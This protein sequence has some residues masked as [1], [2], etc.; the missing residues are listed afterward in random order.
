MERTAED[1]AL[2]YFLKFS[3]IN[4]KLLT[5][6]NND[7]MMRVR[8]EGISMKTKYPSAK[9]TLWA[10]RLIGL[11]L[12]VLLFALP[13]LLDWYAKIRSL[14]AL[15]RTAILAAFY[16]CAVIIAAAL[17]QMEC[18]LRN[19]LKEQVFL[20]ENVRHI[21]TV[22]WCC[23]LVGLICVPAACCY[24]PLVFLVVIMGFL[25]LVVSVVTR[26]MEAAVSIR[27]ENDLT[28]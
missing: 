16:S 23:G 21:R 6:D 19:I 9:I 1:S 5:F 28:I 26:V 3:K 7:D 17:W 27:E 15:E 13:G 2:Q 20:Q 10:N 11:I 4:K 22:Q 8:K 18:L 14:T 12:F 24:Y 25:S